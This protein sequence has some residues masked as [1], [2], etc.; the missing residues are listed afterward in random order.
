[1]FP[2]SLDN[3]NKN[4]YHDQIK[5]IA[6]FATMK[7]CI[8]QA[9]ALGIGCRYRS[10]IEYVKIIVSLKTRSTIS[11]QVEK[12]LCDYFLY[13]TEISQLAYL[14]SGKGTTA[15]RNRSVKYISSQLYVKDLRGAVDECGLITRFRTKEAILD[16][17]CHVWFRSKTTFV[18]DEILPVDT[19][20][21]ICMEEVRTG[22]NK[23]PMC[24]C[25]YWYHK[26][27]LD[28]WYRTTSSCPICRYMV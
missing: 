15:A 22:D 5:T 27:C 19:E 20:C 9:K 21:T 4:N 8:E 2:T 17:L 14:Y 7:E 11:S 12:R 28:K 23:R 13:D 16:I 10:K 1:M 25:K 6:R 26:S 18:E 24:Q 3:I